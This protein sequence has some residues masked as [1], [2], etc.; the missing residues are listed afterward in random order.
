MKQLLLVTAIS[1]SSLAY[2]DNGFY[3][4]SPRKNGQLTC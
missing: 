1:F 2:A 3:C 4:I